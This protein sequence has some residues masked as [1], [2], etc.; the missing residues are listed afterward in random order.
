MGIDA[1]TNSPNTTRVAVLLATLAATIFAAG[2]GSQQQGSLDKTQ[3]GGPSALAA[4]PTPAGTEVGAAST[5]S[6]VKRH[7]KPAPSKPQSFPVSPLVKIETR[8]L[9]HLRTFQ[10]SVRSKQR[11][12]AAEHTKAVIGAVRDLTDAVLVS[13]GLEFATFDVI[14]AGKTVT[15]NVKPADACVLTPSDPG[16]IE[17]RILDDS[18][19][20]DQV[21][22]RLTSGDSLR[23]YLK[24][25]C[26]AQASSA[27][28]GTELLVGSHEG[29]FETA[30][31]TARR[32]GWTIDW[33]SSSDLLQIYV[34][35]DGKLQ[36]VAVNSQGR[37]TGRKTM[38]GTGTYRLRI[39]ATDGW[40][41]KV[42]DGTLPATPTVKPES[43]P[44]SEP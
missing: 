42:H 9:E 27:A 13:A 33:S 7:V 41:I 11:M 26:H 35:K 25:N 36:S 12:A 5:T 38:T 14:D 28:L 37:G 29:S 10:A 34:Y 40:R 39:A 6:P 4:V 30:T 43:A 16:H 44:T 15:V 3:P 24:K 2:C 20:V 18:N 17:D 21:S 1:M 19:I 22:M 31:F 8:A 32:T 23:T